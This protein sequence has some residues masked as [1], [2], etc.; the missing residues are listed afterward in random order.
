MWTSMALVIAAFAVAF[1]VWWP[2]YLKA[3]AAVRLAWRSDPWESKVSGTADIDPNPFPL[4]VEPN[5]NDP[6]P[7]VPMFDSCI[8]QLHGRNPLRTAAYERAATTEAEH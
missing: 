8:R 7:M 1:L 3:K 4:S 5:Q 6:V 2:Q